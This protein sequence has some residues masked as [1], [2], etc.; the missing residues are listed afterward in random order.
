MNKTA[1]ENN[2]ILPLI[3]EQLLLGKQV[4]FKVKGGSMFP[5]LLSDETDVTLEKPNRQSAKY[6][7]ILYKT[8]DGKYVLHRIIKIRQEML[9]LMGDA[10]K[11]KEQ[12]LQEQVIGVVT[13]I[14]NG[15]STTSATNPRY[16]RRVKLWVGLRFLRRGLLFVMRHFRRT[17]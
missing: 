9:I 11:R 1:A 10:L 5:F 8:K 13:T 2:G 17:T 14:K 15:N 6:D 7:I 16:L 4:T 3:E 12:V